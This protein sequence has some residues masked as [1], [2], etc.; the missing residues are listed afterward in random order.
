MQSALASPGHCKC[1]VYSVPAP[2]S[3]APPP[4]HVQCSSLS[5]D[6]PPST[7]NIVHTV[8]ILLL[9]C[10]LGVTHNSPRTSPS[11]FRLTLASSSLSQ[12]S[13]LHPDLVILGS[14]SLG[15]ESMSR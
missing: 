10:A 14:E 11:S 7:P 9:H 2:V 3:H 1:Y 13:V 4:S 8:F 12:I 6:R 5:P 15:D